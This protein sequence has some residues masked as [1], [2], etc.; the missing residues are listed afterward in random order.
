MQQSN[1]PTKLTLA[2]AANGGKNTIPTASSPTA[3][4]ASFYDGFPPLTRTQKSAGGI[5]PSGLD[6]NGILYSLSAINKWNNAGAG[7]TY[8]STFANDANVGGYPKGAKLLTS[9][10]LGCWLSTA[11]NN[12]ADPEGVNTTWVPGVAIGSQTIPMTNA[13]VTLTN[14]QANKHVI[15]ITG[16][17]SANINLIFPTW[18]GVEWL[19][20]NNSVGSFSVTAKTAAGS[21]VQIVSGAKVMLY[22]DGT[23]L[24]DSLPRFGQ[25]Q[26][27]T[28]VAGVRTLNTTYVNTT[29]NVI[30][31]MATLLSTG[32]TAQAE[33]TLTYFGGS[34][35]SITGSA[36][37]SSNSAMSLFFPVP[38]GASYLLS[39]NS[40]TGSIY[41]WI[42][43]R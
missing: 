26:A 38:P 5:P 13:N 11:E 43:L 16:S 21:G 3:G 30:F 9:D 8:D 25:S 27:Y 22:C 39:V 19:V 41:R 14:L 18:A 4:A 20:L 12:T 37:F 24:V 42:E 32:T 7:Y 29:G 17:V 10:G 23:N 2:F 36:A 28:N 34:A 31:V 40:G 33:A 1:A 6:M 15:I 35:V